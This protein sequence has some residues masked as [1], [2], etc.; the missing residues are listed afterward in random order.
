VTITVSAFLFFQVQ[1]IVA[2]AL[3]PQPRTPT[4]GYPATVWQTRYGLV[5]ADVL[6]AYLAVKPAAILTN[7]EKD[8]LEKPLINYAHKNQYR[9]TLLPDGGILW[10]R[11]EAGG[12]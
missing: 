12:P 8:A 2:K 10:L 9:K 11:P 1:P 4:S 5:N 3:L 6:D 7:V